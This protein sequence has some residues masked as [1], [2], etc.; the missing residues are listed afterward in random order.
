MNSRPIQLG[1]RGHSL[2]AHVEDVIRA[3]IR[4]GVFA[5]GSLLPSRRALCADLGIA[6]TTLEKAVKSLLAD[7]T[8][9]S[10]P[11]RGTFVADTLPPAENA[12]ATSNMDRRRTKDYRSPRIGVLSI[13]NDLIL[14]DP[15]QSLF[16][17]MIL[18]SVEDRVSSLG[19]E[20]V[21]RSQQPSQF[22]PSYLTDGAV[23][24][25]AELG[26]GRDHLHRGPFPICRYRSRSRNCFKAGHSNGGH[27]IIL[28]RMEHDSCVDG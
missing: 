21:Y 9:R 10:E 18:H 17:Y 2:A 24:E 23:D 6:P 16:D 25:F 14:L 20:L 19:G 27:F 12:V 4:E 1:S 3:R 13:D 5:P 28:S 7:G 22:D 11:R 26:A 8:L 15:V